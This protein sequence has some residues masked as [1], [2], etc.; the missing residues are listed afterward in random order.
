M[1]AFHQESIP[2]DSVRAFA[3]ELVRCGVPIRLSPAWLVS[4][5]DEN[6]YNL[7]TR[8]ILESLA[9]L[10]VGIGQGNVVF[11]EGN[12]LK[13]LSQY[14]DDG[15]PENPYREDPCRVKCLSFEPDGRVL[16]GNIREKSI[17]QIIKDYSPR[18]EI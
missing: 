1:D 10:R 8:K 14:F 5:E 17:M 16:D 4:A 15:A 3:A 9:D 6:P 13:Y 11:P 7:Q 12:A 2:L 18:G